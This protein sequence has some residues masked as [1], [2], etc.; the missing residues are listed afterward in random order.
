MKLNFSKIASL[1]VLVAVSISVNST[2]SAQDWAR[3]MFKEYTHDF[4]DVQKGQV[5]EYRFKIQN[6]YQEDIQIGQVTSS[7]GCTS[8]SLTKNVL[9]TWEEGE[10][11]CRFNSPAFDGFK[12]ATI[13]VRFNRPYV[14]EVQLNVRGNIVRGLNFSPSSIDFGQVTDT[15][16]DANNSEFV[17]KIQLSHSGS[18]NFRVVDVKS[19]FPHI[20]V[21]LRETSRRGGLVTYEMTTGLKPGV[22]QGFTQGELYV[23][24]EENR[25]RREVPLKFSAK[26]VSK[27]Q[28]PEMITL[29]PIA[30]GEEVK[31]RVLLKSDLPFRITDVTCHSQAFKVKADKASKKVHFVELI[32]TAVDEPGRHEC[33]LSFF[34]DLDSSAS[35]KIKAI[36]EISAPKP[37]IEETAD[38]GTIRAN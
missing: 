6:V 14:G 3:K 9:K 29:G 12:Q 15:S 5:P 8:V 19:T 32:Y 36:V 37:S 34:T 18:P 30:P 22:P 7:C 25:V 2:C 11:V 10:V 17:R 1:L 16:L 31:K 38:A 27:L 28:L 33:E 4:G 20:K 13:T 24:Y 35:G 21:A 23:V 26:V